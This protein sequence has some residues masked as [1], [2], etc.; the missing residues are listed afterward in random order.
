MVVRKKKKAK[1]DAIIGFILNREE[2]NLMYSST[3][4]SQS[5]YCISVTFFLSLENTRS[6]ERIIAGAKANIY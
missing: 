3:N 2:H 4:Y 1:N 5:N 6:S